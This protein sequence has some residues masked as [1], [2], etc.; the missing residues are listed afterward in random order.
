MA[1]IYQ[2]LEDGVVYTVLTTTLY[3]VEASDG[4]SFGVTLG[5]G[6][7]RQIPYTTYSITTTPLDS[8]MTTILVDLT[9]PDTEYSIT[10]TPLNSEMITILNDRTPNPTEYSITTT[11]LDGVM[12][13]QLVTVQAPPR[14]AEFSIRMGTWSLDH[15]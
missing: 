1:A 5:A 14:G 7:L 9:V 12:D 13:T 8:E 6:I 15:I 3:P 10:T 4:V 2:W 11:P